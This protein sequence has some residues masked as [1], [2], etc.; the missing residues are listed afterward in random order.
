MDAAKALDSVVFINLP[1]D[2]TLSHH[3]MHID[4]TIPL[5]VQLPYSN[6]S[7]DRENFDMSQ[8]TQ[9]MILAGILTILAYDSENQ[10]IQYY[11]SI[12]TTARPD[13]KR[14]LT[15]AAILKARNEDFEIAEEIFMALRG[16]DPEDMAIMLNT[17]L[18]L[19]QRAD[20]YRKSNLIEDA[21]AYDEDAHRYYKIVMDAE[22]AVPDAFFNAA[23][24]YLKQRN[25]SRAKDCLETYIALM[26]DVPE[27]ELGENGE[28]K[29]QRAQEIIDDISSRNLDDEL[30]KQAYDLIQMEK[31]EEALDPIREF[32]QKNSSVWNG[33]FLL[34]WALR[35]LG[36]W[37][38]AKAAFQQVLTLNKDH[39][40]TYN[41]IAICNRELGEFEEATGNLMKA[42]AIEPE[43]TKI[44]SNL[45]FLA[46]EQGDYESARK[47]FNIVLEFDPDDRIALAGLESLEV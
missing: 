18:F 3:A 20:Y 9:E 24:F 4:T 10:H 41:E 8:L 38:D 42:M 27:E 13:L 33:W 14:E 28:Y 32:L 31:E 5:P 34:G 19:D 16:L 1:E 15:E 30:F 11:R 43:N 39:V 44:M 23:F 45:A 37:Q 47:Y 17:A 12:I 25:Y 29:I 35:R 7:F 26:V 21:D 40:D 6:G 22:P 36:R 2:F 46:K